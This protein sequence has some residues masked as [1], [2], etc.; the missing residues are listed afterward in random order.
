[1]TKRLT[2]I[3]VIVVLGISLLLTAVFLPLVTVSHRR[4]PSCVGNLKHIGLALRMYS[5]DWGEAFPYENGRTGLQILALR[6]YLENTKMYEC[7]ATTDDVK[8]STFI[9]SSASYCYAGGLTE[10]DSV[11]SGVAADR[12]QNHPKY[13]NILFVDG[14]VKG[15]AGVNWAGNNGGAVFTDFN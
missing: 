12:S 8:D 1:M 4:R 13:G 10:A 3:E 9:S 2:L 11:D 6:G 5:I 14:H 7:S 15:Y